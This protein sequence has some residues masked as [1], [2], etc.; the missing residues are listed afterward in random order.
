MG[1]DGIRRV[2]RAPEER[3]HFIRRAVRVIGWPVLCCWLTCGLGSSALA[4]AV[5]KDANVPLD[6]VPVAEFASPQCAG[7]SVDP[8]AMNAWE[9]ALAEDGVVACRKPDPTQLG[10][11]A[12]SLLPCERTHSNGCPR[13]PDGLP[14][15]VTLR[16]PASCL[17]RGLPSELRLVCT[18]THPTFAS[19]RN[20]RDFS[21]S[22]PDYWPMVAQVSSAD[23]PPFDVGKQKIVLEQLPTRGNA[24]LVRRHRVRATD[25]TS[26]C[27]N[28]YN[29]QF[30]SDI[31]VKRFTN[32]H[33]PPAPSTVA[34]VDDGLNAWVIVPI[35][36]LPIG[37]VIGC[38]IVSP[39]EQE[40]R[41]RTTPSKA[42]TS[43]GSRV[44]GQ[45]ASSPQRAV[46]TEV[47]GKDGKPIERIPPGLR[48][49]P[50]MEYS[51]G[52]LLPTR[53]DPQCG[54]PDGQPNAF[55]LDIRRDNRGR[56]YIHAVK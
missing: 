35:D 34:G 55:R 51:I 37:Q 16:T 1:K 25:A 40:G 26:I 22:W 17:K 29:Y 3:A 56:A 52:Q 53:Y 45:A 46:R 13:R 20:S 23:C 12:A 10:A 32:P 43:E 11:I 48:P 19:L 44:A 4:D 15:A 50:I 2:W 7:Y 6:Y 33:C 9:V 14:N 30:F 54:G 49:S 36:T 28:T 5:C 8:F 41:A 24:Y 38:E 18:A 21:E 27:A 42:S 47:K 39:A 31:V